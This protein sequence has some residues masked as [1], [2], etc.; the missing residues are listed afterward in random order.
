MIREGLTQLNGKRVYIER[1]QDKVYTITEVEE[2]LYQGKSP[3]QLI[4][5]TRDIYGKTLYLDNITQVASEDEHV[6]HE[7]LTHPP[8]I[9]H[10][11]P[12]KILI[13]GGGDG[14]LLREVLKHDIVE[15]AVL[16]E[17]DK[18]V[19]EVVEKYLPEIPSGSFQHPK[20]RI[21]I[22]DGLVFLEE[23]EEKFDIIFID[24]TDDVESPFHTEKYVSLMKKC[25]KEGGILVFQSLGVFEHKGAQKKILKVLEKFFKNT[26][27]YVVYVPSFNGL[28]SF[29][30]ASDKYSLEEIT[31]EI[32]EERL[33]KRKVKTR[34]YTPKAH[35]L[36]FLSSL[37]LNL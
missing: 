6:Y 36:L 5:V 29:T 34:F 35:Q 7:A 19:I 15:E 17:I 11:N 12:R 9:V 13:I 30:Y 21:I 24:V 31:P 1:L 14:G 10:E 4:E 3:Y 28:W 37:Y 8:L 26:G 2:V 25:L 18:M 27:V 20:A 33:K 16:V 22:G 23:T 32:I